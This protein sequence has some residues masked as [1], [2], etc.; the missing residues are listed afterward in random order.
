MQPLECGEYW[1]GSH[2]DAEHQRL[3]DA[4]LVTSST[5]AAAMDADPYKSRT[6]LYAEKRGTAPTPRLPGEFQ[7][8]CIDRGVRLEP[9]ALAALSALLGQ[10]IRRSGFWIRREHALRGT[11]GTWFL[12]GASPDGINE[13]DGCPV[14]VKTTAD[15]TRVLPP[16]EHYIQC[17]VQAF[18]VGAPYTHYF[19][20]HPDLNGRCYYCR[21]P[22]DAHFWS[23]AS[24]AFATFFN[25]LRTSNPPR[26]KLKRGDAARKYWEHVQLGADCKI[27]PKNPP[28]PLMLEFDLAGRH[29]RYCQLV[30]LAR[31]EYR[32]IALPFEEE[33]IVEETNADVA[34]EAD[35]LDPAV[36]ESLADIINQQ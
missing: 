28:P 24:K 23:H 1:I 19:I 11:C 16:Y 8:R 27:D 30:E 32:P 15:T 10:P 7:Q 13:A 21:I 5:A 26:K 20:Y 14:E 3:R 35:D 12:I 25:C 2:M 34:I 22:F 9:D 18:C 36:F 17:Q 6:R 33:E 4:V 31:P 29:V